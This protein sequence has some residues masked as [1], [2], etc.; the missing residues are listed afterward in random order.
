M[1][2]IN[3]YDVPE[4]Q[5]IPEVHDIDLLGNDTLGF[6]SQIVARDD[7]GKTIILVDLKATFNSSVT[8]SAN[9]SINVLNKEIVESNQ[10]AVQNK[11]NIFIA[12]VNKH[13]TEMS[14]FHI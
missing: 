3:K 6:T 1:A 7:N 11:I 5:L 2:E 12:T 8:L 4:D 13:L 14:G 9:F 10:E